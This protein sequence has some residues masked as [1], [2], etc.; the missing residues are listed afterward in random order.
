MSTPQNNAMPFNLKLV[1]AFLFLMAAAQ[2]YNILE[3]CLQA[4]PAGNTLFIQVLFHG[5]FA[6]LTFLLG[7]QM[8]LRT[9]F[10]RVSALLLFFSFPL[11]RSVNHVIEPVSWQKLPMAGRIQEVVI[12][13][14][15]ILMACLLLLDNV[16]NYFKKSETPSS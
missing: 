15:F 3:A 14:V 7:I 1:T 5:V 16:R 13:V 12:A 9:P 4:Q 10:T 8:I 2:F 11:I 6:M